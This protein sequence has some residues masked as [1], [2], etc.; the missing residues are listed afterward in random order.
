MVFVDKNLI[1]GIL[2]YGTFE[3]YH[4]QPWYISNVPQ[5]RMQLASFYEICTIKNSFEVRCEHG[6]YFVYTIFTP[7]FKGILYGT[8]HKTSFLSTKSSSLLVYI[9]EL[10]AFTCGILFCNVAKR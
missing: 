10:T 2:A 3:M 7:Y 6:T 4:G 9:V 8:S 1:S 5:A